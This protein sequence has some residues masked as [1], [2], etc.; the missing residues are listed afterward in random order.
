N[1]AGSVIQEINSAVTVVVKNASTQAAGRGTLVPTSFQLLQGQRSLS[2]TYT[3]VEPIV[4]VASD[5]LGNAP[6]TTNVINIT[7]G[8]PDSIRVSS[9]PSWVG[10]NKHATVTA[11][12]ID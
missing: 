4:I 7:P 11:R 5:D 1:D 3:F 8:L 12:L 6:A 10:G 2:A 9:A